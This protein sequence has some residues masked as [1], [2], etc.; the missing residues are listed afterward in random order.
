MHS[1]I[2]FCHI[3]SYLDFQVT[4]EFDICVAAG[5]EEV[6]RVL[7]K[8]G[9]NINAQ[10]QAGFTALY[11]AA[12]ENHDHVVKFLLANGANQS[13]AT[14]DGFTPLGTLIFLLRFSCSSRA[15][16]LALA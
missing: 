10:S 1:L 13:L 14:E 2:R 15:T 6:V 4:V 11:M 3:I 5:Q 7:V 16:A 12:Q 8:H 9:A